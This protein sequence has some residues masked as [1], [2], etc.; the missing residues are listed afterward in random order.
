MIIVKDTLPEVLT[1]KQI[2]EIITFQ[3]QI[4][5]QEE[6][7]ELVRGYFKNK[8]KKKFGTE[9]IIE[10]LC[11]EYYI[12][13]EKT[14]KFFFKIVEQDGLLSLNGHAVL[15]SSTDELIFTSN[16]FPN[17]KKYC[18]KKIRQISLFYDWVEAVILNKNYSVMSETNPKFHLYG[19][20]EIINHHGRTPE[21]LYVRLA[22]A[23]LFCMILEKKP[24]FIDNIEPLLINIE[25]DLHCGLYE[26]YFT[27]Y[28]F[29]QGISVQASLLFEDIKKLLKFIDS[30]NIFQNLDEI[31]YK[32]LKATF[33]V[34]IRKTENF[35]Q[36]FRIYFTKRVWWLDPVL[37]TKQKKLSEKSQKI[38]DGLFKSSKVIQHKQTTAHLWYAWWV[39]VYLFAPGSHGNI[40]NF[41]KDEM[42]VFYKMNNPTKRGRHYRIYRAANIKHFLAYKT[43][44]KYMWCLQRS[45]GLNYIMRSNYYDNNVPFDPKHLVYKSLRHSHIEI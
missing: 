44:M 39:Y 22:W 41:A 42:F 28:C 25:A 45:A 34:D 37:P 16:S 43:K 19:L 13:Q 11:D 18:I 3:K 27:I 4:N 32:S 1:A 36:L 24:L 20:P 17:I 14:E 5:N 35:K 2:T 12:L 29:F 30:I 38:F 15:A 33:S 40:K 10:D 8:R 7:F 9:K 21:Q 6:N 23:S 26:N 31:Y